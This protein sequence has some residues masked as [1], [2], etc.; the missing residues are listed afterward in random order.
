[1]NHGVMDN[2]PGIYNIIHRTNAVEQKCHFD[3]KTL[4]S[5]SSFSVFGRRET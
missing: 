5:L 3:K 1:M 2:V 4:S